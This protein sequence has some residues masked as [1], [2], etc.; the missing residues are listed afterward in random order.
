MPTD[1]EPYYHQNIRILDNEF[2][3]AVPLVANHADNLVFKQNK[4]TDSGQTFKLI[5]KNCGRA[6]TGD[7]EVE[8]QG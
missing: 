1:K 6:D 8:R 2:D 5:L 3:A 7:C 4:L